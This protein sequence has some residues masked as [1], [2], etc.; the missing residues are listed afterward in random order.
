MCKILNW[1]VDENEE[2]GACTQKYSI[3]AY[4][5]K[6][7]IG[8]E[9][10]TYMRARYLLVCCFV[11]YIRARCFIGAWMENEEIGICMQTIPISACVKK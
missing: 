3:S 4:M 8:D 10:G 2:I 7:E 11:G 9:I 1:S 5:K 6:K